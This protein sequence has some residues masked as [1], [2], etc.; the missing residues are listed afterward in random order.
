MECFP[1]CPQRAPPVWHETPDIH[2]SDRVTTLGPWRRWQP[3]ARRLGKQERFEIAAVT[4]PEFNTHW[5]ATGEPHFR[6]IQILPEPKGQTSPE[7]ISKQRLLILG[8]Y[9]IIGK[10]GH[11]WHAVQ[12]RDLDSHPKYGPCR[13]RRENDVGVERFD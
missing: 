10:V 1:D 13:S 2:Q 4:L 9:P 7:P 3:A 8:Y 12:P 11:D 5:I 6:K